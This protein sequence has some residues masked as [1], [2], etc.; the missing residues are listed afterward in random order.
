M[1]IL[2]LVA[3]AKHRYQKYRN[4][5]DGAP[6]DFL[7]ISSDID[8]NEYTYKVRV[9]NLLR[10]VSGQNST[11]RKNPL[12]WRIYLRSL[13][14]VNKN[15]E[16]SRNALFAALDECPW[17]KVIHII[18]RL[19]RDNLWKQILTGNLL[20]WQCLCAT[21]AF[22]C[23]GPNNRKTIANLRIAW[24]V[25]NSSERRCDGSNTIWAFVVINIFLWWM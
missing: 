17:N 19:S 1:S 22:S 16:E 18:I 4:S 2:L 7:E 14:D 8:V 13:L 23:A 12:L 3:A 5:L 9:C 24:R 10:N 11:A 6:A 21:G 15:F 25:G 20:G